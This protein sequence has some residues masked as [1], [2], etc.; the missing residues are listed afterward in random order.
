MC[1]SIVTLSMLETIN[2]KSCGDLRD[3]LIAPFPNVDNK[4]WLL[5]EP[6]NAKC[7]FCLG[8]VFY[9]EQNYCLKDVIYKHAMGD[10]ICHIH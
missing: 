8:Y 1:K 9:N 6:I 5:K 3:K 4:A 10:D 2:E 7:S